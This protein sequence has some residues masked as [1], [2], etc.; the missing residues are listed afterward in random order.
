MVRKSSM[1]AAAIACLCSAN[2]S[3]WQIGERINIRGYGTAGAM[4][5][6]IDTA[7]YVASG[8][9]QPKGAGYTDSVSFRPDTK[10]GL[11]ADFKITDRISA[12]VQLISESAYNNSWYNGANDEYTPSLE[13]ANISFKVTDDLTLRAGRV[14]LPFL[15]ISEYR[16]VGY[17]NHWIRPPVDVYSNLPFASNDGGE[18]SYRSD[19]GGNINTVRAFGG[20]QSARGTFTV[21]VDVYGLT[22]TFE[23][24]SLTLRGGYM[25]TR[26][27]GSATQ[28][29]APLIDPFIQAASAFG[30]TAA[31]NEAARMLRDYDVANKQNIDSFTVG[32]S[33][34]PG[35]WFVMSEILMQRS[36]GILGDATS[37]YVSGGYRIK[38]FTPYA[39]YAQSKTKER[40]EQ[41]VPVATLPPGQL[42]FL[43]ALINSTII[44]IV[45]TD[46]SQKT[47]SVGTRWDIASSFAI[48][49]QYDRVD[50]DDDS[51]GFLANIQPDYVPGTNFNAFSLTL[52]FVF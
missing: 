15:M 3:A 48:K 32:A 16:K 43:G 6:D 8:Y 27:E 18:V 41:G 22:N 28:S 39:T 20:V 10:L 46:R 34:D 29:F 36:D 40:N 14:V 42:A 23:A 1:I 26:F 35:A 21:E 4:Y 24:G 11:Q 12:V 44:P 38:S 9:V 37:G 50:I 13:W 52:D 45:T 33:Y 30:F 2:A 51:V 7:D 47:L 25:K 31:A 19:F 49:A 17:A 5:A